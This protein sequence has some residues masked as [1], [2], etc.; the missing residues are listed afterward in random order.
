MEMKNVLIY[1]CYSEIQNNDNSSGGLENCLRGG[2]GIHTLLYCIKKF[3]V[4]LR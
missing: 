1:N 3:H 2:S 4:R